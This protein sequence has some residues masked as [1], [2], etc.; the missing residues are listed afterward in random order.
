MALGFTCQALGATGWK[1]GF[2]RALYCGSGSLQG[3]I[4][5]NWNQKRGDVRRFNHF[6]SYPTRNNSI[7]KHISNPQ[8]ETPETCKH[9][10]IVPSNTLPL[11]HPP[12]NRTQKNHQLTIKHQQQ[13]TPPSKPRPPPSQQPHKR[14]TQPVPKPYSH[15]PRPPEPTTETAPRPTAASRTP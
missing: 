11:I 14:T 6:L 13:Q 8:P 15:S 2:P 9:L 10:P 3:T 5:N 4:G 7:T 12:E 1:G